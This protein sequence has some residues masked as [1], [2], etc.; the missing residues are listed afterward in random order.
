MPRIQRHRQPPFRSRAQ[1]RPN[2]D[3]QT[4]PTG[5]VYSPCHSS[6]G[7]LI[8]HRVAAEHNTRSRGESGGFRS[9]VRTGPIMDR[10]ERIA[11]GGAGLFLLLL[12]ARVEPEFVAAVLMAFSFCIFVLALVGFVKPSWARIPNRLASVWL[13]ALSFWLFIGGGVLLSPPEDEVTA[14]DAPAAPVY[15]EH[16]N[17]EDQ[18]V[19]EEAMKRGETVP[20][21]RWRRGCSTS[22]G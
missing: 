1:H 17:T 20:H 11:A 12:A 10:R 14:S 2:P 18:R 21:R 9:P 8:R 15:L 3:H 6:R 7:V 5:G 13:L 19:N 4:R 22:R 16:L